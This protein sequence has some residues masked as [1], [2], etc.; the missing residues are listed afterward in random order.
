MA[1]TRTKRPLSNAETRLLTRRLTSVQKARRR[2]I[3]RVT[4]SGAPITGALCILT[5]LASST[6]PRIVVGFWLAVTL[7]L[8][9]WVSSERR[10]A[11]STSIGRLESAL[12]GNTAEVV[13]A[14]S[15]QCL[16]FE[17]IEDE[18]ACYAFQVEAQQV[19]FVIGQ[20][21]YES[22]RFPNSDF[23]LV[24]I[25]AESGDLVEM[26]FLSGGSKLKPAR[27]V[28]ATVKAT[29]KIPEH[30]TVIDGS[31]A[32]LEARLAA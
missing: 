11:F 15:P 8:I 16:A 5:L 29:L 31:L 22:A 10:R 23:S 9:S 17:E 28:P 6:D 1:L 21:F 12:R 14:T 26:A 19:L 20:D 32:D 27:I 3:F 13:R 18:G 7:L 30:L 24:H 25:R 4:A 2:A